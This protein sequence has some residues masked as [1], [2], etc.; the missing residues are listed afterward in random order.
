[1]SY[2]HHALTRQDKQGNGFVTEA[3]LACEEFLKRELAQI[4]PEAGFFAEESGVSGNHELQWVIDPLDGTTNFAQGVPYFCIS[5][6]LA[7]QG[8]PVWAAVYNPVTR[9]LFHAAEGAG[10]FKNGERISVS[11]VRNFDDAVLVFGVPYQKNEPFRQ[12]M[13][14]V[15][16]L[17][18]KVSTIR[19]YGAV[20]LDQ[21]YLAAGAID[22]LI[23]RDL[24][25]WDIAA[26]TLLIS[27]AGGKAS[28]NDG[29]ELDQHYRTFM[30]SNGFLYDQLARELNS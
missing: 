11:A 6:A 3:D 13:H 15:D 1:M 27:Q 26:G 21:A 5:V 17:S 30:A 14:D 4:E 16:R 28:Q 23:F 12:V 20:A 10:A 7:H 8:R 25:W 24:G 22:A 18:T 2:F 29:S 19:C 9:E